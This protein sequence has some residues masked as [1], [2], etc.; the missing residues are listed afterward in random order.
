MQA[1]LSL[2][3]YTNV[4]LFSFLGCDKTYEGPHRTSASGNEEGLD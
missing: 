3:K 4:G 2:Q 1:S